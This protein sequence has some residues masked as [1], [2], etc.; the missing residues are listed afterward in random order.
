MYD[1]FRSFDRISAF[2]EATVRKVQPKRLSTYA[3]FLIFNTAF[4]MMDTVSS[5]FSIY[6][7]DLQFTKTMI[8]AVTS[9]SALAA[10]AVQPVF[11]AMMDRSRSRTRVL[12]ILILL[13]AVLYPLL[14]LNSS[15]AYILVMYTVYFIFRR[16]QPALNTTLSV[17]FAEQHGRYY[18]PIRMM[19]AVGYTLM[20][21][22]ISY[23][24]G[25]EG[26][27]VR[28]FWVY[29]IICLGNILILFFL[30]SMPGHNLNRGRQRISPF[31]LLKNRGVILLILYHVLMASANGIGHTYFPIFATHDMGSSNALYGVMVTVGSLLE[32]PFLFLADRIIRRIG[33]K[34]TVVILGL[35]TAFRWGN[36]YLAVNAGQL[37][38]TQGFNFVN[39]L[40][41]VVIAVLISRLVQP[42][43]KTVAQTLVA[44]VQGVVG[45]LVS[46]MLG[47]LLADHFGI[48]IL[49]LISAIVAAGTSVLFGFLLRRNQAL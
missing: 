14:L 38:I 2:K 9:V 45:I 10:M 43:L 35:L 29:S 7:N 25:I 11:G 49:F 16:L 36:A 8:G 31:S 42:E 4:F 28:T 3:A 17:E 21:T 34:K 6:L 41:G 5:Y 46:S 44:T 24:A 20:M 12:Q 22:L 15:F 39:I 30:P 47:G 40:E 26:G 48:R 18:G 23:I 37:F 33:A 19:G 32:I 27:V 13:T 1:R